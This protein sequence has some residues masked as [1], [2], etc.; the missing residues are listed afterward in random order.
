MTL[1]IIVQNRSIHMVKPLRSILQSYHTNNNIYAAITHRRVLYA[2]EMSSNCKESTRKHDWV[3]KK[4]IMQF[5]C[6]MFSFY[7]WTRR[8][9]VEKFGAKCFVKIVQELSLK[10]SATNTWKFEIVSWT[11]LFRQQSV[12]I[13]FVCF[14]SQM[15]FYVQ[16]YFVTENSS[17]F[18]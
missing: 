15:E 8:K 14:F 6:A 12:F 13:S 7:F 17:C 3:N 9:F 1:W 18:F 10:T 4:K 11:I 16:I 5:V 2:C